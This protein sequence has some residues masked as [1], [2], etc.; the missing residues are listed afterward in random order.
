MLKLKTILMDEDGQ[1]MIEYGLIIGL[2]VLVVAIALM[3]VAP[4]VVNLYQVANNE[5]PS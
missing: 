3:A 1:S 4:K 2:V 5:V